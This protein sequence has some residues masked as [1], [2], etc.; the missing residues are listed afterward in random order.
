MSFRVI[1]FG[2]ARYHAGYDGKG[3]PGVDWDD[4]TEDVEDRKAKWERAT[5]SE[6]G[7]VRGEFVL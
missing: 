6:M 1:D 7:D 5:K 3:T 2:R 4:S